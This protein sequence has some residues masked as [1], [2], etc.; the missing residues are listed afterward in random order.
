MFNTVVTNVPGPQVP[1]YMAGARLVSAYGVGPVMDSMG[2]FHAVTSYCGSIAITV[3]ACRKMMPD[4]AFYRECLQASFDELLEAASKER[5]A[6]KRAKVQEKDVAAPADMAQQQHN[7]DDLTLIKGVGARLA[8]RL[9]GAGVL[10]FNQ[11]AKL[12]VGDLEKLDGDLS[13]R[14]RPM[15]DGWIAQAAA[16]ADVDT[17]ESGPDEG[18]TVH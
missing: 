12:S 14:G 6:K 9:R 15:R 4:P 3:T 1:L 13:L 18:A 2:L 7:A 8:E 10:T 17:S 16:L 11:I 5:P